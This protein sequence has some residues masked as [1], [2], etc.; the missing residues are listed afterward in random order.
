MRRQTFPVPGARLYY[1]VRGSGP[2]LLLIPGGNGDAGFYAPLAKAAADR[3]TVVAYDRRGFSRSKLQGPVDDERRLHTDGD[4]AC[5]LL[6]HLVDGPAYVFGSS[7]GAIVAFDLLTRYPERIRTLVAHEPPAYRLLPDGTRYARFFDE[8]Y[9]IYRH[10]GIGAAMRKFAAEI[11]AGPPRFGTREF[12]RMVPLLRRIRPNLKFWLE[13]ELRQYTRY[14]P[15]VDALKSLSAQLVL[16]GGRESRNYFPYRPNVA[17]AE[18]IGTTVIDFP[19]GHAGY[20]A[21]PAEFAAELVEVLAQ[22][23]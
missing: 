8:V 17:L 13:H 5:R 12:W 2:V 22:E 16:A 7:S 9:N 21:Y 1:E 14:F 10:D 18:R 11:G 6:D 15:D 20:R 23:R 19:G 4:D 3:Y